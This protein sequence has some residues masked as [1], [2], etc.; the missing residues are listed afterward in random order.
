MTVAHVAS[1]ELKRAFMFSESALSQKKNKFI[2]E[3]RNTT[4]RG[5]AQNIQRHMENMKK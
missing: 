5:L 3:G 2:H 1:P 4:E